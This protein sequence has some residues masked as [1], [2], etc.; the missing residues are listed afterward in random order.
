MATGS[1]PNIICLGKNRNFRVGE[2]GPPCQTPRRPSIIC[3][4]VRDRSGS[5]VAS[6][7][8]N[9]YVLLLNPECERATFE[10]LPYAM[11]LRQPVTPAAPWSFMFG[12]LMI[13]VKFSEIRRIRLE[14]VSSS[15]KKFTSTYVFGS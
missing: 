1:V 11:F 10:K 12:T 4:T 2:N 8:M 9:E 13:L 7:P 14:R 3:S 6:V 15:P 5:T